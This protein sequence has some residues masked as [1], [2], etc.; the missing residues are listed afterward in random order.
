MFQQ[1]QD[2]SL[3]EAWTRFKDLLQKVPHHGIDLWLKVQI[4]YDHVNPTTMRT[5]DQSADGKLRDKNAEESWALIE[6]RA[7]YN[8]E[9]QNDSKEFAKPVKSISL[10]HDVLN[11]S[12]SRLI[13]LENRL[14]SNF[15][16]SQDARLSKFEADF[17]QQQSEMTKKIDTFLKAINDR[18]MGA[19]P[20]D[21]VK[22]LK[23]N[24]N[25]T[26]SVL[27]AHSYLMEDPQSSSRTFSLNSVN[28]IKMCFKPTN[29]F[30]ED[31]LQVKTLTVNKIGTPNL[32]EPKKSLED[33]FKDLQLKL[34]VL[35]VLAHAPTHLEEIHVTWTQFGK[36][37]DTTA[38]LHEDD[39]E[40]AYNEN[41]IRTLV[42]YS[43]PSNEG[44]KDI[45][46]L[47]EGN[48]VVH[49]RSD[50]IWL[51]Q[52]GCSF[53]GLV[54]RFTNEFEE[55]TYKMPHKIEQYNS[56][57]YLE[58]EHTKPVYFRNEEDK[59]RG[60]D[61]V[62]I[63]I[64]GFY[65]ECVE[66]G[67]GY[68]TGLEEE[69]GVTAWR[70]RREFQATASQ[71]LNDDVRDL[72]LAG[73][74]QCFTFIRPGIT[75]SV[76]H[77]CL[78][79]HDLREPHFAALKRI[80]RYVRDTLDYGLQLHASPTT[81]LT[82]SSN[83][84]REGSEYYGVANAEAETAWL[85]N[86]LL[87]LH[88][89]LQSATLIYYD[90]VSVVCLSSNPLQRQ[91]TKHVEIDIHFVRDKVATGHVRVLHVSLRYQYADIFTKGLHLL[92]LMSFGP[93]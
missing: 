78:F 89:P 72:T 14:V 63:K 76:Q 88:S 16:A 12:E 15:M 50:T 44:Y 51:V 86:L 90:N 18:M 37:R 2:E 65:K 26:Y 71:F 77:V 75:Y 19:L 31:Q 58:K 68:L 33:E 17:K 80:L 60:V 69:G 29:D 23:L 64:L 46:E 54:V 53:H 47:S 66:L 48:N 13:E 11:A 67:P 41:P 52:N 40:M 25:P 6:D 24:V 87:K 93:V 28:A 4:F 74:L 8:N 27:F 84:D 79:M 9:S 82:V 35:E 32:K 81:K 5:I 38:T 36:K 57:S 3:F 7:L 61:Y 34:P 1:H 92:C 10:P 83:A 85:Q 62:M 55:I 42:D 21:T 43:K 73:A 59:R 30:Q 45:T 39:H 56:L 49:L 91:R 20:S 70:R 22:N